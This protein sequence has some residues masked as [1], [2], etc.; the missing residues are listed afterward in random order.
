MRKQ[1]LLS[2]VFFTATTL[3]AG[4]STPGGFD[5]HVPAV[6]QGFGGGGFEGGN[7]K[8]GFDATGMSERDIR[9][10]VNDG[11]RMASEISGREVRTFEDLQALANDVTVQFA[12][13]LTTQITAIYTRQIERENERCARLPSEFRVSCIRDRLGEVSKAM[14]RSGEYAPMRVVLESTVA[15]LGA[16]TR[17]NARPAS[18][19]RRFRFGERSGTVAMTG[20]LLPLRPAAIPN[21]HS[22]AIAALGEARTMLLRSGENSRKRKIHFRSVAQALDSGKLLLRAA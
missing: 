5:P 15:K 14:P 7:P 1:A 16:I 10:M 12:P 4:P 20:A 21:A 6:T 17:S 13:R 3:S 19:A 11:F 9:D 22:R 18:S 8:E 2:M